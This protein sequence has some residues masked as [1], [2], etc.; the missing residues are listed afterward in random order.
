[1][2][3]KTANVVPVRPIVLVRAPG[4]NQFVPLTEPGQITVGTTIDTTNGE[5][6]ITIDNGR[7]GLDTARFW[8]G[9]FQFL[10]PK[11]KKG[12][13]RFAVM[14]LKGGNFKGC[15][16]APKAILSAFAAGKKPSSSRSVRHLWAD[17]KG[18]FRTVGR[19]SSAT[20]R[21]T[22]WLTDDRCGLTLTRV[23]RGKVAVRDFV[24]RKVV[25]VKA[26]RKY[27]ARAKRR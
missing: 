4:D 1:V 2:A 21:G 15:P 20:I 7:G 9:V 17:G 19:F 13:T 23:A 6:E 18:A 14:V 11:V 16:R 8:G 5:V 10:Q 27:L 26:P 22:K 3:G 24:K 25:L 12:K